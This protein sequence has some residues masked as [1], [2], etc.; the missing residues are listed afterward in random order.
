MKQLFRIG[1]VGFLLAV[2]LAFC[3]VV[4]LPGAT[5][6][7]DI[8]DGID[9]PGIDFPI[10]THYPERGDGEAAPKTGGFEVSYGV[11]HNRENDYYT[12]SVE[13]VVAFIAKVEMMTEF[14][15]LY[16]Y[17]DFAEAQEDVGAV[18]IIHNVP[19]E[20]ALY[21]IVLPPHWTRDAALPVLLS[22]NG[23][24][25]SNNSLFFDSS[26]GVYAP[27]I[28]WTSV[29][30]GGSGI[31]VALSNCGGTESQGI[32]D[33]TL[34]S[35]GAFF[36]FIAE[37]GGDPHNVVTSGGS[38]GGG[39]SLVWAANPL[40]LDYTVNAVFA[41]VPP[42][43]Y[44][45]LSQLSIF[46]YPSLGRI[47]DFLLGD[48]SARF[49]VGQETIVRR[50]ESALEILGG[51]RDVAA[52]NARGAI[53]LAERLRGK[54]LLMSE[55]THD[56]YFQFALFLAFDRRLSALGIDHATA[57]VVGDGHD[58]SQWLYDQTLEY[59]RALVHGRPYVAP[60]GRYYFI[61]T[62][63]GQRALD[64]DRLPF[65]VEIPARTGVGLPID[66]SAC[67][68]V[69]EAWQI[70]VTGPDGEVA[71]ERSGVFDTSECATFSAETFD[72]VGVYTWAFRYAGEEIPNTNTPFRDDA[73]CGVP[74]VTVVQKVQPTLKR[75]FYRG[76]GL[77]FGIDQFS[78]Q[79]EG[80][81]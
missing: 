48:G 40:D 41:H 44:G 14:T 74:A 67:G 7:E 3:A 13:K 64:V 8:S 72:S 45:S 59:L 11:Y 26:L 80:C 18:Q 38:R 50:R 12:P 28:A 65:T 22:G 2:T 34:R 73:G 25:I 30:D 5:T 54:V 29:Q 62:Y 46:T 10:V 15:P 51:T 63:E 77:S 47:I 79:A 52:M 35:V 23:A 20:G 53:G 75:A 55:G 9:L 32:D 19:I 39:A 21:S 56:S 6:Q 61:R 4:P 42:T 49:N 27:V 31:I 1:H 58:M 66:V 36:D 60:S 71:W 33:I 43:H 17:N 57:I 16:M 69:G 78:V 24:G 81:D 37:N 68:A 70:T 76:E